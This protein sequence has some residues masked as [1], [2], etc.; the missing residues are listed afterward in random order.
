MFT[1]RSSTVA[2]AVL[3]AVLAVLCFAVLDTDAGNQ[4]ALT[5][6]L[7]GLST[8]Y[9]FCWIL[10]LA[11]GP[12][13][14]MDWFH[15]AILFTGFYSIYFIVSGMWVWI[16]H[17]YQSL[18]FESGVQ[19]EATVNQAFCLGF[20]S[21]GAFGLGMR[22]AGIA[23]RTWVGAWPLGA[24]R[25]SLPTLVNETLLVRVA[26]SYAAVGLVFKIYHLAQFGTPS[27][28]ILL[29]LSPTAALELDLSISQFVIMMESMLD[30]AVLLAIL[31]W[32]VRYARTGSTRGWWWIAAAALS[33]A[34][35]DYI[36]SGKRSAVIFF[37]LLPVIW[38]NYLVKP[39]GLRAALAVGGGLVFAI[40][41]LLLGRIALPLVTQGLVP[42]DY[43]GTNLLDVLA[44]YVDSGE[45][46]TFDMVAATLERRQ[47]LLLQA[48]GT[49]EG[50]LRFTF[51]SMVIFIPRILW[52]GKPDYLDLSH[53]YRQVL[54]GPEEGMGIAPTV[55]GSAYLFFDLGGFVI[56]ML[57]MGYLF[58]AIYAALRPRA[59]GVLGVAVY[60]VVFWA[61]FQAIRFGTL[62]FVTIIIVQS[63]LT[64]LVALW[65]ASR[66]GAL[67]R[68]LTQGRA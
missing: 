36:I 67:W 6:W 17:D 41:L 60:S 55:W 24:R 20:V 47:E 7:V 58:Q 29:Y 42:T 5:P 28:D 50:F 22:F 37:V 12:D 53:V 14:R 19:P 43:I 68:L 44:F 46:S 40:V 21:V 63:M 23:G 34:T 11:R 38:F 54:V 9:L 2:S 33:V 35:L 57:L 1:M 52:P 25:P 26:L 61:M 51:S 64:G 3:C 49:L 32:M 48:G 30:W 66:N 65:L 27:T 31:V 59:G 62:G 16:Y 56:F 18:F 15:P 10:P 45:L 8:L 13:D 39:L 4:R